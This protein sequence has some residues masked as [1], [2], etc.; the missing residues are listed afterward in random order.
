MKAKETGVTKV[1]ISKNGEFTLPSRFRE[2]DIE[3]T[4]SLD[5]SGL[6]LTGEYSLFPINTCMHVCVYVCFVCHSNYPPGV[7]L[8]FF[9][10]LIQALFPLQWAN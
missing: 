8:T 2:C 1:D 6:G 10:V 7:F 3:K 5:F 9:V 4:E